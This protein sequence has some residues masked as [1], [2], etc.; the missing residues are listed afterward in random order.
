MSKRYRS[1]RSKQSESSKHVLVSQN[2]SHKYFIIQHK[3]VIAGRT[4]VVADFDH[5]NL[6]LRSSSLEYLVTI[7]EPVYPEL[8]PYFYS[9]LSFHGNHIRTRVKGIDLDISFENLLV[10]STTPPMG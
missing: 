10:Y 5:L 3:H 4:V 8:V 9:N 1:E 2:A 7:R 6:A